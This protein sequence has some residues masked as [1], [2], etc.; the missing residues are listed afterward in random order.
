MK[1]SPLSMMMPRLKNFQKKSSHGDQDIR[2]IEHSSIIIE[3]LNYFECCYTEYFV[4]V[5]I[6]IYIYIYI[7]I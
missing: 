5:V 7:Y 3:S 6:Y 2:P 4:Y 1:D